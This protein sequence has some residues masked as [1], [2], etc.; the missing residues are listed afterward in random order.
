[1]SGEM[2][3]QSEQP[4]QDPREPGDAILPGLGIV[5]GILIGVVLWIFLEDW[6]TLGSVGLWIAQG[7]LFAT[8]VLIGSVVDGLIR[9]RSWPVRLRIRKTLFLAVAIMILW[10]IAAT[11]HAIA[12]RTAAAIGWLVAF[13]ILSAVAWTLRKH[14]WA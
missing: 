8:C 4:K 3:D 13:L 12:G 11:G 14:R 6:L 1:M 5:A 10:G 7:C 9:P 2:N